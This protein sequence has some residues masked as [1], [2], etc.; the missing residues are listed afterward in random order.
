MPIEHHKN[1][2]RQCQHFIELGGDD[3]QRGALIALF[4]R[5]VGFYAFL[6]NI[7]AYDQPGVEAGKLA[8]DE[9]LALRERILATLDSVPRDFPTLMSKL[10]ADTDTESALLLLEH[11]AA[12]GGR[13]NVEF[14]DGC[15][16]RG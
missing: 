7:N 11:L 10:G 9:V 12:N 4:E 5:A 13:T 2:I 3:Q 14:R 6:V 15:W 8:A 16:S 1:S